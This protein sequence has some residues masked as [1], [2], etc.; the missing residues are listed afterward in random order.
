MKYPPTHMKRL[1]SQYAEQHRSCAR[2]RQFVLLA[3]W[4]PL[5][6]RRLQELRVYVPLASLLRESIKFTLTNLEVVAS[7]P[8]E[9]GVRPRKKVPPRISGRAAPYPFP[10][11]TLYIHLDFFLRNISFNPFVNRV[12]ASARCNQPRFLKLYRRRLTVLCKAS[13]A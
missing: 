4:A 8:T 12:S 11:M 1:R 3:C 9:T 2:S 7:T 13:G 6:A 5:R 10:A